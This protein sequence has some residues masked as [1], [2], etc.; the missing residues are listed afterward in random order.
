MTLA[1][2]GCESDSPTGEPQN[3]DAA[4]DARDAAPPTGDTPAAETKDLPSPNPD[5]EAFQAPDTVKDVA[6]VATPIEAGGDS[7][8]DAGAVDSGTGIDL[9]SERPGVD[10]ASA[11]APVDAGAAVAF[12][13]RNDS[14]CCIAIDGCMAVAYLYSKAPG[15]APPPDFSPHDGACLACIPPAIQ[16]L[17]VSGQCRGTRVSAYSGSILSNHCGPVVLDAGPIYAHTS[18]DAGAT[19]PQTV[20]TCGGG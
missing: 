7:T 3:K 6:D 13:C 19:T 11:E 12:P 17:C 8:V 9:G 16:V 4:V 18:I 1:I 15:A 14:D 2:F 10:G 5:V 20:W